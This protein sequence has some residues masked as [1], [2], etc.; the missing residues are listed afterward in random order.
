M[1]NLLDET[2]SDVLGEFALPDPSISDFDLRARATEYYPTVC[3]RT[4]EFDR[5]HTGENGH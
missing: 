4:A 2:T 3:T 5:E 1:A